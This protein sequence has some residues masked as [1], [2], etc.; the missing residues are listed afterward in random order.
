VFAGDR[1]V[2]LQFGGGPH[3]DGCFMLGFQRAG[4]TAKWLLDFKSVESRYRPGRMEWVASDPE[5]PGVI[6]TLDALPLGTGFG[7]A[8]Q[9]ES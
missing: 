1:P 6:V 2:F 5:F 8:A 7:M 9:A 3:I 4:G